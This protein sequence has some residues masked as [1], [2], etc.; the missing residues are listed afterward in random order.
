LFLFGLFFQELENIPVIPDPAVIHARRCRLTFELHL[1][2][3]CKWCPAEPIACVDVGAAGDISSWR[4]GN[5]PFWKSLFVSVLLLRK[6]YIHRSAVETD[7][8][9]HDISGLYLPITD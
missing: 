1:L 9:R 8:F 7:A 5:L 2:S 4:Y 3:Q 6:A